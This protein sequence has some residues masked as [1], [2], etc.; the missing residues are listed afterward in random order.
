MTLTNKRFMQV[1]T[2]TWLYDIKVSIEE[3]ELFVGEEKY[4]FEDYKNDLKTKRAVERNLETIGEAMNRI[5]LA[6]ETLLLTNARKVVDTRN[7]IVHGYET[8]S[9]EVIWDIIHN[10]L[11][12]LKSEVSRLL[13]ED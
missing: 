9:S 4:S 7:R 8:V 13:E 1:E 6:N 10:S 11:P 12:L 5:L 3:I 2:K